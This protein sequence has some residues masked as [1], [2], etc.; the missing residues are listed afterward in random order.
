M[1]LVTYAIYSDVDTIPLLHVQKAPIPT[2]VKFK[3]RQNRRVASQINRVQRRAVRANSQ[4]SITFYKINVI[5]RIG[6]SMKHIE[7]DNSVFLVNAAVN[8]TITPPVSAT[9]IEFEP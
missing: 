3:V 4:T 7:A 2:W 6:V 5:Q 9:L 1:Q 8:N